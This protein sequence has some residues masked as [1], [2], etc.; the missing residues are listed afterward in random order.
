MK[1]QPLMSHAE[2]RR[3]I[4]APL[5]F[6]RLPGKSWGGVNLGNAGAVP[7]EGHRVTVFESK[8]IDDSLI[9]YGK[10]DDAGQGD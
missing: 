5:I 2:R 6:T 7:T 8:D 3:L 4:E 10:P 1:R 9:R